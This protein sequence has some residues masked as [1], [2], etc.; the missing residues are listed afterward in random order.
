MKI[1]KKCVEGQWISTWQRGH[2]SGCARGSMRQVD[3]R[4]ATPGRE[5]KDMGDSTK[6]G[7]SR[8]PAYRAHVSMSHPQFLSPFCDKGMDR[9]AGYER[10]ALI[11]SVP[12][13]NSYN[14]GGSI[15]T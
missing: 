13:S 5:I 11:S 14:D 9:V 6:R 4:W 3:S 8:S 7:N 12:T 10:S 1:S 2:L 15:G